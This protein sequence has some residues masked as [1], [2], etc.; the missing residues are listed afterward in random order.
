MEHAF[1]RGVGVVLLSGCHIGDCH[2]ID[3]NTHAERRYQR[4]RNLMKRND[5]DPDRMQLVWV[6]AA[7]G[8][9]FQDKVNELVKKLRT[10]PPEEIKKSMRFFGDREK[11]R[12]VRGPRAE[13]RAPK[14]ED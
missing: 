6:S 3:A 4:L 5:L 2:Y 10:V 7:E 8:Q 14:A 1:A 13:D 11:K 12:A 9:K